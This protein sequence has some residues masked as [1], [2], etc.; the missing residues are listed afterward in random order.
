MRLL[1]RRCR[2]LARARSMGSVRGAWKGRRPRPSPC[3]RARTFLSNPKGTM[4]TRKT[5]VRLIETDRFPFE[6]V[7]QLAELE[8]C[9]KGLRR[10]VSHLHEWWAT[11]LGSV[12]RGSLLGC[13]LGEQ[14]DLA[15][16]F[17]RT[18]SFANVAVFDPFMGS[19]TTVVEAHKL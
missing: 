18:H 8:S 7:S 2:T 5:D 19:G 12:F 10:P 15:T 16:E 1:P 14:A 11:R 17:Y 4:K 9:P 6:V 13:T 3:G